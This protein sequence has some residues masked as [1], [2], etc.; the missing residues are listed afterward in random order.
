VTY[1][2]A[3][4]GASTNAPGIVWNEYIRG[5]QSYGIKQV[6]WTTQVSGLGVNVRFSQGL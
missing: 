4:A 3:G 6:E 1:S 2:V 5:I